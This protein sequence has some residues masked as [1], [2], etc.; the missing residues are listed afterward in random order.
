MQNEPLRLHVFLA[1]AGVAGRLQSEELI[2]KGHV[3]V[4]GEKVRAMGVKVDPEVD[5]VKVDGN[6]VKLEKTRV[7]LKLNKPI[8]VVS[9]VSDPDRRKTVLDFVSPQY[10]QFRLYPVGRLDHDSEGLILLTNDGNFAYKMT[11][12]KFQIPRV[13]RVWIA[14]R[15][16]PHEWSRLLRGV[17]LREGTVKPLEVVKLESDEDG[18]VL[19]VTMGIGWFRVVRRMF[20][21]LNHPVRRLVRMSHGKYELGNLRP[22]EIEVVHGPTFDPNA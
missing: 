15:L 9:T 8:N 19:D 3:L 11:H 2:K 18:Q 14:G 20:K 10:Q 6:I 12:P 7:V 5:E 16:T 22:G 17:P 4:N 21:G 13:Y 1:R